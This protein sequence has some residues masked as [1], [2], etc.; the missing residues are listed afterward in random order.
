MPAMHDPTDDAS[1]LQ[2]RPRRH[3]RLLVWRTPA[4][5][6]V[7]LDERE[8]IAQARS[9][10]ARAVMIADRCEDPL[11]RERCLELAMHCSHSAAQIQRRLLWLE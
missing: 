6:H 9:L 3:A 7:A 11:L 5:R 8:L 2:R 4:R 1:T 10:G